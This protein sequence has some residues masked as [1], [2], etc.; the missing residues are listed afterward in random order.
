M[1][2]IIYIT[3]LLLLITFNTISNAQ[4]IRIDSLKR[5]LNVVKND[6]SRVSIYN[7]LA[8]E[9]KESYP[10]STGFYAT[11]AV[12][13]SQKVNFNFGLANAYINLGNSNIILGNYKNAN[14]YFI[15]AQNEFEKLLESDSKNLKFKNGLARF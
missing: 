15:K 4:N 11:K 9:Y 7:N 8:N 12:A 13:L 3:T 6:T 10:D 14:N 2:N 5:V 1:K